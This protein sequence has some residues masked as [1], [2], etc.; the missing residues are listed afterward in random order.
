KAWA[1][2][3]LEEELK[4]TVNQ[5]KTQITSLKEGVSFLGF[6][7][8]PHF[9]TIDKNRIKRFKDNVR[10]L[11]KRNAGVPISIVIARLN[12][13]LRGWINYYRIANIKSFCIRNMQWIRRRLRMIRMKQWKTHKAMHKEMNRLG[14][15]HNDEKMN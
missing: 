1:T 11:T 5:E 7:I 3:I 6:K 10:K 4:L 13:F 15:H 8:L 14:V 12:R 2:Q 9:T